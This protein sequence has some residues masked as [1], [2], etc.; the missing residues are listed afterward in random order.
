M[1]DESDSNSSSSSADEGPIDPIAEAKRLGA[2]LS[3]PKKAKI[4]RERKIQTNP[5]GK[6]RSERGE[7]D[8]KLSSWQRVQEHK[9]EY[10]KAVS[11]KLRCEACKETISKKSSTV[12]KHIQSAK[13]VKAKK[14][15]LDSKKKDQSVLDLI[16]RNDQAKHPKGE[17][18]P[19]DMRL[20]RFELVECFLAAGIPLSKKLTVYARFLKGM[21]IGL[22]RRVT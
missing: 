4:A 3:T 1:A 8:P 17:T 7:N 13:H 6:S 2:N 10:L 19:L 22:R 5:A 20:Y 12:K 11:G 15:I 9:G 14:A 21:G 16:K 18:L